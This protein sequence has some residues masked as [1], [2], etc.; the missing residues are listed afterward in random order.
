MSINSFGIL[1]KAKIIMYSNPKIKI[2][3]ACQQSLNIVKYEPHDV[4]LHE[5]LAMTENI[6]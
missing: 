1:L 6:R 5:Y 4:H 2:L 3:I